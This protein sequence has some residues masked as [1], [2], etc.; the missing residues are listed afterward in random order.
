M[1]PPAAER[2]ADPAM[3]RAAVAEVAEGGKVQ[4]RGEGAGESRAS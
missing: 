4:E 1:S 2:A 3:V